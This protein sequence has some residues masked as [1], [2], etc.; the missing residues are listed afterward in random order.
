[1]RF[2]CTSRINYSVNDDYNAKLDK[3]FHN[4]DDKLRQVTLPR[5]C[6]FEQLGRLD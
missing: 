5:T 4:I 3:I 1:M 6:P 2:I